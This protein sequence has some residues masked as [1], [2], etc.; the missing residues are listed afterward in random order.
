[1]TVPQR[2]ELL[3][4]PVVLLAVVNAKNLEHFTTA[5]SVSYSL[6]PVDAV[7]RTVARERLTSARSRLENGRVLWNDVFSFPEVRALGAASVR[8]SVSMT[9]VAR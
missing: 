3:G 4:S 7:G 2:E 5:S 9:S 6:A 8:H 1:M